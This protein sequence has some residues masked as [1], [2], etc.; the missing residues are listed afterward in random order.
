MSAPNAGEVGHSDNGLGSLGL[1]PPLSWYYETLLRLYILQ[2]NVLNKVH[3][4]RRPAAEENPADL[5]S[6]AGRKRAIA[7]MVE[8]IAGRGTAGNRQGPLAGSMAAASGD[9]AVPCDGKRPL[10]NSDGSADEAR[11]ARFALRIP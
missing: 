7:G 8:G 2:Y 4:G 10:G 9:A 1:V 6:H 11:S 5:L 3:S